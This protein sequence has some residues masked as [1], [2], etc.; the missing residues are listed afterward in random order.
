MSS[1]SED[2]SRSSKDNPP[3]TLNA[4][5]LAQ[6]GRDMLENFP[7]AL[8]P[9]VLSMRLISELKQTNDSCSPKST[10]LLTL[11]AETLTPVFEYLRSDHKIHFALTC[12]RLFRLA[13]NNHLLRFQ[14]QRGEALE[15]LRGQYDRMAINDGS[16]PKYTHLDFKIDRFRRERSQHPLYWYLKSYPVLKCAACDY[17]IGTNIWM[18]QN[19]V[20]VRLRDHLAQHSGYCDTKIIRNECLKAFRRYLEGSEWCEIPAPH[21]SEDGVAHRKCIGEWM[22]KLVED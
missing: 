15:L 9:V 11:P 13:R 18:S 14:V 7:N 22:Q 5:I 21:R 12:R 3:V 8:E 1:P 16:I 6:T 20:D 17:D 10:G 19:V 2:V 4:H